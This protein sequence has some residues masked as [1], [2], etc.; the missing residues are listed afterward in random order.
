M[1]LSRIIAGQL[2]QPAG[3]AAKFAGF[4]WD[5]RNADLNDTVFNLLALQA[6]DQVLEIGFGGGYLLNRMTKTV[7]EGLIAGIDVSP[8]MVG[9]AEK[10]FRRILD[11]GK[12][13][14]KCAAAEHLPYSANQFSKVCSVNSIFYWGNAEQGI[15]EIKRVLKPA[16][17]FV[18]CFTSKASLETKPFAKYI[19]L[20]TTDEVEQILGKYGFCE[21][22]TMSFSDH[23]RQ[24]V[25]IVA[26]SETNNKSKL[27]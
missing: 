7:T 4:M 18:L 13:E 6:T 3:I 11:A 27:N 9:H 19:Q 25:G 23:Y 15:R 12:L 10:R 5:R 14:I 26:R 17:T 20:F 8:A 24:Y 2:A 21:V 16:G 1:N 22:K